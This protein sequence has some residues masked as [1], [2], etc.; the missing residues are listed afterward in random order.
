MRPV[1]YRSSTGLP[2]TFGRSTSGSFAT[3]APGRSS[4]R[5]FRFLV[6]T[7]SALSSTRRAST[8]SQPP[9]VDEDP[10]A[11]QG[12]HLA[13][14]SIRHEGQRES[15]GRNQTERHGHM[16]ERRETDGGGQSYGEVLAERIGNRSR[17]AEAEPAE[18]GEEGQ[19]DAHTDESPLLA[20]GAEEKIRVRVGEVPELLL[21]FSK[22]DPEQLARA[23]PDQRLV[24]LKAGFGRCVAR[25]E[26]GQHTGKT[27]LDVANLMEDQNHPPTG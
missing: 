10:G 24:D 14:A 19:H 25:I 26:E 4:T 8:Y 12:D 23:N 15:G 20:N 2:S 17:D 5:F 11:K 16:H 3:S 9:N 22:A 21:A 7:S 13:G 1:R 27:I 18:Q 6:S